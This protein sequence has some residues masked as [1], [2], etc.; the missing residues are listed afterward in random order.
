MV[1]INS[2]VLFF[3]FVLLSFALECT[4]IEQSEVWRK[5]GKPHR[6]QKAISSGSF[7]VFT[8]SLHHKICKENVTRNVIVQANVLTVRT[9]V[10]KQLS[11]DPRGVVDLFSFV[12]FLSFLLFY[13]TQRC[14]LLT[15]WSRPGDSRS[16]P[17]QSRAVASSRIPSYA[18]VGVVQQFAQQNSKEQVFAKAIAARQRAM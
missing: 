7:T 17:L 18:Y 10:G 4:S 14:R 5:Q 8:C 2:S 11:T 3:Q 9:K 12:A 13:V 16:S 15:Y 1:E 6:F